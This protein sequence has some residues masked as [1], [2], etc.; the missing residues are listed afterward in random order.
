MSELPYVVVGFVAYV[1]GIGV[2]RRLL[3][4]RFSRRWHA[5][6]HGR[7]VYCDDHGSEQP[8]SADPRW[9]CREC[10]KGYRGWALVWPLVLVFEFVRVVA[11]RPLAATTRALVSAG[12]G[13]HH[14]PDQPNGTRNGLEAS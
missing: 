6:H 3:L 12:Y 10:G 7:W 14:T 13:P 9:L 5:Q 11:Y 2:A 4:R 1:Y 8:L